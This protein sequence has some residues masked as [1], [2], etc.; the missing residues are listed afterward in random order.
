[1]WDAKK[2]RREHKEY[3]RKYNERYRKEHKEKL[4]RQKHRWYLNHKKEQARLKR[5]NDAKIREKVYKHYGN[6]CACCGERNS[7]FFTLDHIKNDG[8]EHRRQLGGSSMTLYRWVIQQR[9]PKSLRLLC[10][11]CNCGRQRNGGICPHR[12]SR[13]N[14]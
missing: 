12:T 11:N 3:F 2:Y 7:G 9:Y 13:C 5:I 14:K 8:G 1:M 4:R 10:Y 6:R